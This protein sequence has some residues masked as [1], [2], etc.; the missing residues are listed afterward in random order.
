MKDDR[1]SIVKTLQEI[2]STSKRS[3]IARLRDVFDAVEEAKANGASNEDIVAGLK[4]HGLVFDVN[5]FKNA[6]SRLLKEK[7]MELLIQSAS[8][9]K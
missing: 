7:A 6:R 1:E 5:T 2:G 3:K 9:V 4:L 8:S